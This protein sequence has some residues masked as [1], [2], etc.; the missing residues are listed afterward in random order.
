MGLLLATLPKKSLMRFKRKHRTKNIGLGNRIDNSRWFRVPV[1]PS[2]G[3]GT[4]K[5]R[6][7]G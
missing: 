5:D 2:C 1:Y 6:N 7:D 4:S 3:Y